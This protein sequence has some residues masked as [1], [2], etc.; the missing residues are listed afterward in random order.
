MASQR[1]SHP[2]W[3]RTTSVCQL[4]KTVHWWN[5]LLG[6]YKFIN[7]SLLCWIAG[8]NCWKWILGTKC[9]S[10]CA[11]V[12]RQLKLRPIH[13]RNELTDELTKQLMNSSMN[14]TNALFPIGVSTPKLQF[15][16]QFVHEPEN[17]FF[18]TNS[19]QI[20]CSIRGRINSSLVWIGFSCSNCHICLDLVKQDYTRTSRLIRTWV[21]QI[22][23]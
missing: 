3:E 15:I 21:V 2:E 10:T 8:I 16:P 12:R 9:F 22:P 1:T 4:K 13:I 23:G 14:W 19:H 7:Y 11:T 18:W 5:W 17:C 20:V 6:L